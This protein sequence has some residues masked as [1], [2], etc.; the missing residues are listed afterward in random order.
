MFSLNKN[1]EALSLRGLT[2]LGAGAGRSGYGIGRRP[3]REDKTQDS[4]A[5]SSITRLLPWASCWEGR[6]LGLCQSKWLVARWGQCSTSAPLPLA[7]HA[8][9]VKSLHCSKSWPP[10]LLHGANVTGLAGPV[11]EPECVENQALSELSVEPSQQM[12]AAF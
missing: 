5:F 3:C 2:S 12:R 4:R 7:S 10:W 6:R 11:L 9:L 8:I 1:S